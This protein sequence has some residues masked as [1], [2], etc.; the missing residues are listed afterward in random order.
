MTTLNATNPPI[1]RPPETFTIHRKSIELSTTGVMYGVLMS[2]MGMAAINSQVNLLFA[3]FG[4]MIGILLVSGI[5]GRA[6]LRKLSITRTL[7][8][9]GTVGA[10]IMLKYEVHNNKRFCPSMS[11][12]VAETDGVEAFAVQPQ[13]YV[14][15]APARASGLASTVVLAKRRGMHD[16]NRYQIAASF[17]FGFIRRAIEGST[18]DSL[19]VYPAIGKVD[20]SIMQL[21]HGQPGAGSMS[22]ASFGGA[23][24][25]YGVREYRPGDNP[26]RIYWRRSACTGTL[27]ARE[28]THASPPRLLLLVDTYL[29]DDSLDSRA[30]VERVIA[31]AASLVE[32]ALEEGMPVGLVAWSKY[33]VS[34]S[35]EGGQRHRRNLLS[36]LA[37]LPTNTANPVQDLLKHSALHERSPSTALLLTPTRPISGIPDFGRMVVIS[38][39]STEASSFTFHKAVDF[40]RCMPLDK[41]TEANDKLKMSL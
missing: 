17:P 3:I 35:A 18:H 38:A 23:D 29:T 2:F 9:H 13:V 28:M 8:E 31:M 15:H 6:S 25:F 27:V 10:P 19:M 33:W 34:L 7:P 12:T 39:D 40:K 37:L 1:A 24:E 4:M 36:T 21:C 32:H 22:N 16:L 20:P 11:L 5:I 41:E 14:L 26:R 30:R